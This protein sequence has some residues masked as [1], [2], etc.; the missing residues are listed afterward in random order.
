M[1]NAEEEDWVEGCRGKQTFHSMIFCTVKANEIPQ[2]PTQ[3]QSCL[4][5]DLNGLQ[6]QIMLTQEYVLRV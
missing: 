2:P 5:K 3:T 6:A 4:P 1:V